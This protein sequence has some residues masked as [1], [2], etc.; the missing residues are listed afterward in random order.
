MSCRRMH[1]GRW[2]NWP[3]HSISPT[4]YTYAGARSSR[5]EQGTRA[6]TVLPRTLF[7]HFPGASHRVQRLLG[8]GAQPEISCHASRIFAYGKGGYV[9]V[10]PVRSWPTAVGLDT[11]SPE[12]LQVRGGC[13][14]LGFGLG[15]FEASAG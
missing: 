3:R 7:T 1:D 13:R 10:M 15:C 14:E 2:Q 11:G 9:S 6:S 4:G 8:F 12:L 5:V